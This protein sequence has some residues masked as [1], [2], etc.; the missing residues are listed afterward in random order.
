MPKP[1]PPKLGKLPLIPIID[2]EC[3][4]NGQEEA[5]FGDP[6]SVFLVNCPGSCTTAPGSVLGNMIYDR[7]SSVCKAAIHCGAMLD[8]G[9]LIEVA[10]TGFIE[11]VY[12]FDNFD[13]VSFDATDVKKSMVI[14]KPNSIALDL[15]KKFP[16]TPTVKVSF[17]E[18][19]QQV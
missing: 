2:V 6:G 15:A 7:L 3:D 16:E 1:G 10:M 18:V 11:K 5:F 9:G 19:E 17:L 12:S 8:E 14:G 4:T 13:I